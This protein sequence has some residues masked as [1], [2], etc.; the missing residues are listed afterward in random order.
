MC[1]FVVI[2]ENITFLDC[3]SIIFFQQVNEP[4]VF[5]MMCV[6]AFTYMCLCVHVH[7]C[8]CG[9]LGAHMHARAEI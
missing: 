9:Y 6:C 1:V 7:T 5:L 4:T 2:R 8:A 3:V